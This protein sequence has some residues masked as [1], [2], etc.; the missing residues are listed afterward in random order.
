[1]DGIAGKLTRAALKANLPENEEDGDSGQ[2]EPKPPA[3]EEPP[4]A[5]KRCPY[6]EPDKNQKKGSKGEGV[7]WLQWMLCACGY[8]VG[9]AGI[10]GDF[11]SATLS[12]VRAFQ[13]A[14]A[15]VVDG[16]AGKLTRA[17]LKA[18]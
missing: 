12:A 17:A 2:E 11:G 15:L 18:A 13:K 4:E 7:K 1:V 14:E 5:V 6:A 3:E 16:I 8:D 9:K 10:D